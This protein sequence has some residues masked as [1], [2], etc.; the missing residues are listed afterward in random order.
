[1][2]LWYL[3]LVA[4]LKCFSDVAT[5]EVSRCEQRKGFR[6]CFIKYDQGESVR[7]QSQGWQL[8][9]VGGVTGRGCSTKHQIF[10]RLCENHVMGASGEE[11]NSSEQFSNEKHLNFL[12]RPDNI[13]VWVRILNTLGRFCYCSY[14]LCNSSPGLRHV[15]IFFNVFRGKEF[16]CIYFRFFFNAAASPVS[17]SQ[18]RK[19][20]S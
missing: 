6:S 16:Y 3:L 20:C 4:A 9:L 10:S 1:M 7:G 2:M 11:R 5:E 14:T 13:L 15:F 19:D 8:W 12:P 18:S 17:V